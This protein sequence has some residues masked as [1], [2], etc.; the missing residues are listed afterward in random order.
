MKRL[1]FPTRLIAGWRHGKMVTLVVKEATSADYRKIA[2]ASEIVTW[3]SS[4]LECTSE[5]AQLAH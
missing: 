1:Q 4:Y 3:W 5:I 2:D